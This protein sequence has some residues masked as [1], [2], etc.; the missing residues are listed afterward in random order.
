[1]LARQ[2]VAT[3]KIKMWEAPRA[4]RGKRRLLLAEIKT[5]VVCHAFL[6]GEILSHS[7]VSI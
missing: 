6:T 5:W 2:P 1:M 3:N 4:P 7:K